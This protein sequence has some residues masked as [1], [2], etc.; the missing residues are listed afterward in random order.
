MPL[1]SSGDR[2][3]WLRHRAASG[4]DDV[5]AREQ[6]LTEVRVSG[7]DPGVE[8]R[9]G[10]ARSVEPGDVETRH[11]GGREVRDVARCAG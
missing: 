1:R 9:D 7:V 10:D 4:V 8:E 6:A 5:D 3:M 2:R 11:R